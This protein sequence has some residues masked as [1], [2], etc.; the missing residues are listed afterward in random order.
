MVWN[1][2]WFQTAFRCD[3]GIEFYD[4]TDEFFA[5]KSATDNSTHLR[6]VSSSDGYFCEISPSIESINAADLLPARCCGPHEEEYDVAHICD[7]VKRFVWPKTLRNLQNQAFSFPKEH[8]PRV[9]IEE[10]L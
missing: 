3:S 6:E 5:N 4:D 1:T 7:T 8:S 2:F 10:C 9:E